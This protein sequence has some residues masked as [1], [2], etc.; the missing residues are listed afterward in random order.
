MPQDS[1]R[2]PSSRL[3]RW[4]ALGVLIVV[5]VALYFRDGRSLPPLGAESEVAPAVQP[6]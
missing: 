4:A 6:R 3:V 2:I 5:A 1:S